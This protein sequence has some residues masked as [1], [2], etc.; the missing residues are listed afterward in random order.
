[1]NI[2]PEKL[3]RTSTPLNLKSNKKCMHSTVIPK[4]TKSTI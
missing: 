4:I 1:M 3:P 2:K